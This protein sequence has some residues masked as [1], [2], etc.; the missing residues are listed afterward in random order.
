MEAAERTSA[1]DRA[2]AKLV[3]AMYPPSR[4][5]TEG[6]LL[7]VLEHPAQSKLWEALNLPKPCTYARAPHPSYS[8]AWGGF[9]VQVDQVEWG[10]VARK[11]TWLYIVGTRWV[12]IYDLFDARPYPGRK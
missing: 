6:G 1:Y 12:D 9:S 5:E 8:D 7:V 2:V 4:L 3:Q 10:H 11:R